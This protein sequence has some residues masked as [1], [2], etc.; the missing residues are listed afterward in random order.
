MPRKKKTVDL[1]EP[2]L[3][4]NAKPENPEPTPNGKQKRAPRKKPVA[5]TPE[6]P[7]PVVEEVKPK[8]APTRARRKPALA[9]P[10][11][12]PVPETAPLVEQPAPEK[13][14]RKGRSRTEKP[15]PVEEEVAAAEAPLGLRDENDLPIPTWRPVQART[16]RSAKQQEPAGQE[17]HEESREERG[18]RRGRDRRRRGKE[19]P[20]PEKQEAEADEFSEF[21]DVLP[22]PIFR[23]LKGQA[24][25]EKPAERRGRGRGRDRDREPKPE[26]KAQPVAKPEKPK[27]AP[28][29]LISIPQD[30][31]QVVL[32]DGIPT[33][34]RR[35]RV[36]PPIGFFGNTTDERRADTVFEELRLAAEAGVHLH[37]LLVDLEVNPSS[38][39]A[40]VSVAAYLVGRAKKVDPDS[41]V[42]LRIVFVAPRGWESSYPDARY[43]S[44]H[45][46]LGEPSLCDNKYWGVARECLETFIRKLR[47][48]DLKD[49]ILGVHLERGEWFLPVDGGYDDSNAAKG[50]FKDWAR[51]RYS[52][53]EVALRASWFDGSVRFDTVQ[54]PPYQPEGA[55]GDR[56]VRSSRKQRRYV[57]YHLFLSDATVDRI[58][59]LAY[60]AKAASEGY[61]LVGASYGYTFEWAHPSSGHLA[62]GKLLRTA[63]IDFIAGPPSYKNREAGGTAPFPTAI[64]SFALN[65]KLYISEEDFKTAIGVGQDPDDFN[66]VIRTPQALE[67]V[68]WRGVGAALAHGSGITW[69]D[70]WGNGWLKTASI[71]DRAKR[72]CDSLV[73]RMAAPLTDPDVA[74]FV[75]E[76]ALAYLVDPNA[77]RLLIQSA[78]ESAM[79]S[80]LSVGF[81]LLS[82]LA[83]RE[84]FPECKLYLFL[85]AWDIRPDLRSAI[86][87][88]LHRDGKVLFWLY[89]AGLFDAGRDSLERARDVTGIAL[90]PQP[91]HSRSGTTLL[92]RRH[93]LVEAF[94]NR[95][96]ATSP[97]EPSYFGIN[98]DGTVL[99]EYTQTGLPSFLVKEFTES[100]D[101]GRW[102]SVFLGE[103]AV[104]PALI[105]ALGEMAGAHIWNFQDDLVHVRPPFLVV[106]C[107][108][109][110]QRAITLPSKWSAYNL[111]TQQ[112]AAEDTTHLRF[113][114][115]AGSTHMFLVGIHGELEQ[116]LATNPAD[117]L[118]MEAVP[119]RSENTVRF[120]AVSFDVPIM[121]L[122]EWIEGGV[123]DEVAEELLFRPKFMEEEEAAQET[124][125]SSIP[126]RRRRRRRG[127][128]GRGGEEPT[129]ARREGADRQ[130]YSSEL[131]INV[132]FR[133]RE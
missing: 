64:D 82:D 90:K 54:I 75:D 34:V 15:K 30:A 39:D 69:M 71:W 5:A 108:D 19:Q 120:D 40:A 80:G 67:S 49:N 26:A 101:G 98:E 128:N 20:Q 23:K 25:D 11:P 51:T 91:F 53:D 96:I 131:D 28:K 59:D 127:G 56:F 31:P 36:Y 106:H 107:K 42:L 104:T 27:P 132:M 118:K 1:P 97:L 60:A 12:A 95:M 117:I 21:H 37:A 61:F 125:E 7:A 85:N 73:D 74:V 76:R 105:R 110:G 130:A 8:A 22:V 24:H 62:L 18:G 4:L 35:G 116:I 114:A 66:P 48:L 86:K 9:E 68:H 17:A 78:R 72:V 13:K 87:E 94:P 47:L 63:E 113:T 112:W 93:P 81:F 55:E 14:A 44:F 46:D 33:L 126:G 124:D 38:V 70:L 111:I 57:D 123:T 77:F 103:P 99:G 133:K 32:R 2:T 41:Q 129:T 6:P 83:H 115:G 29:A 65:G 122:N 45:G 102:T 121:R 43:T 109:A 84:R 92:N 89:S 10:A 119:E 3:E 50:K 88:R 79:R 16:R 58:S 100:A 52:E